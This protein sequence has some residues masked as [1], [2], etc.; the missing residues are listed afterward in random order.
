MTVQTWE[1]QRGIEPHLAEQGK[2]IQQNGK[3]LRLVASWFIDDDFE[4]IAREP[5]CFIARDYDGNKAPFFDMLLGL[6]PWRLNAD[7]CPLAR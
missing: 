6:F 3:P 4:M 5:V 1:P 7:L 2:I